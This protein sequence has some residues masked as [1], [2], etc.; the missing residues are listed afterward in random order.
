MEVVN[1]IFGNTL[2]KQS[3]RFSYILFVFTLFF[4]FALIVEG[5]EAFVSEFNITSAG[6]GN[7]FTYFDSTIKV[8][9][10]LLILLTIW[11]TLERIKQTNKQILYLEK[12]I[13][14]LTDNNSFNNFYRHKDE[15]IRALSESQSINLIAQ[16]SNI[17]IKTLL[18]QYHSF[19]YGRTYTEFKPNIK[20][21]MMVSIES[22]YER[23]KKSDVSKRKIALSDLN[24]LDLS[25][26]F[27]SHNYLFFELTRAL[28]KLLEENP[29]TDPTYKKLGEI[30]KLKIDKLAAIYF[31]HQ[32]LIDIL[33]FDGKPL[34][35]YIV[36]SFLYHYELICIEYG[37]NN[38]VLVKE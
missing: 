12:Q 36:S 21:S 38:W 3:K 5:M 6:L 29:M 22:F 8:G 28:S 2:E 27:D 25:T 35:K 4:L 23:L 13:N 9:A 31:T 34:A 1:W 17:R 19:Y 26:V 10:T 30:E 20:E 24:E 14:S 18:Y 32:I 15:F 33:E 37:I 11:L 16:K 7:L